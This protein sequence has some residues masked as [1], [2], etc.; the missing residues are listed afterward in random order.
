M[1]LLQVAM[2]QSGV[3]RYH[4]LSVSPSVVASVT[5]SPKISIFVEEDHLS[6]DDMTYSAVTFKQPICIHVE[7]KDKKVNNIMSDSVLVV[8]H[9]QEISIKLGLDTHGEIQDEIDMENN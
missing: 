6:S 4:P 1:A 3:W 2:P 9:F 7:I 5:Y 8:G